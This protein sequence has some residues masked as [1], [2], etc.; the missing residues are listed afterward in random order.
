MKLTEADKKHILYALNETCEL[1]ASRWEN[2]NDEEEEDKIYTKMT[3]LR[4]LMYKVRG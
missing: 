3:L 4:H 1:L 2:T